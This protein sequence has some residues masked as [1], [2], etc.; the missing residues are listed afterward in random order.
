MGVSCPYDEKN[1]FPEE[2]IPDPGEELT[3]DDKL[4]LATKWGRMYQPSEWVLLETDYEKMMS[5][6]DIQD[7]DTIG[8]LVLICKTYLKI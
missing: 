1:F 3:K 4:Y 7:S 5:S 6:F 8:A 2:E